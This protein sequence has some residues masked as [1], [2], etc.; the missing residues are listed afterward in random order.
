MTSSVAAGE[1]D[2]KPAWKW[3][4][5]ERIRERQR[6]EHAQKRREVAVADGRCAAGCRSDVIVDG[7]RNP[8]LLTPSELMDTLSGAFDVKD[9]GSL[10]RTR[11]LWT[12]RSANLELGQDFWDRLYT[13]GRPFFDA[14]KETLRMSR[15]TSA[16]NAMN[17]ST[18]VMRRS[19]FDRSL[20]VLR[21]E[22]LASARDTFGHDVFDEFLYRAIAPGLLV[23]ETQTASSN[24]EWIERGCR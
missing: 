22:A 18:S 21:A 13:A 7:R 10:E 1:V 16:A 9:A 3:E 20:C 8:E 2:S 17:R 24:A 19:E 5:G 23:N 11:A 15:E 6:P 12:G 14:W 4:T